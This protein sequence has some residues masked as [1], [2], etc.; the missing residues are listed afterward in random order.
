[1]ASHTENRLLQILSVDDE[2][3]ILNTRRLLLEHE[4]YQVY[5]AL[6]GERA[7]EL[8]AANSIDL[9]LLDYLM[10]GMDGGMVALEMK[11]QRPN[12]PIIMVSASP[13]AAAIAGTSVDYVLSKGEG[14]VVLF[15]A[16]K[17]ML[18]PDKN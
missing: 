1:M 2:P 15:A 4:G 13:M 14:P 8:F 18:K 17:L 9:V 16:M 3:G 5:S 6:D 7:L 12:I 11:R 10:P